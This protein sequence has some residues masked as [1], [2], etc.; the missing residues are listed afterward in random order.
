[1]L[2]EE[3]RQQVN[4]FCKQID[5]TDVKML[6]SYG[7]GAQKSISAFST[8]ITSYVKPKEFG[9]VGD[10]LRELRV[11]ISSTVTPEKKG[12]FP[13]QNWFLQN[14]HQDTSQHLE[15]YIVLQR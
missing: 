5:V 13:V 2:S 3:E 11:A 7:S 6:N 1:M 15:A 4:E 8:S 12:I 10:S 9:E 14:T